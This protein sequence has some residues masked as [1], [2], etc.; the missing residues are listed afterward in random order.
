[1]ALMQPKVRN[2]LKNCHPEFF[3]DGSART[4]LK[5]L[6]QHPDFKGDPK[7]SEQLQDAVDYV[8]IIILQFEELYADLPL[9][10]LEELAE[11][12]KHRLI[13]R[14]VKMQNRNITKA[15]DAAKTEEQRHEL[16]QKAVKLNELIK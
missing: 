14:Y 7:L 3:T 5:F 16:M 9:A 15:M 11:K 6:K 13:D 12:L 10:D 4:V 2:L 8:K 1:M